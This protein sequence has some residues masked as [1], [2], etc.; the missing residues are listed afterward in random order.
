[1]QR[2]VSTLC[3]CCNPQYNLI[4]LASCPLTTILTQVSILQTR[5]V[6]CYIC[7]STIA[8]SFC[9]CLGWAEATERLNEPSL[10]VF[11]S[12][13]GEHIPTRPI[14]IPVRLGGAVADQ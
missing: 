9:C 8:L 6:L 14:V 12:A 13:M 11:L 5:S 7:L 4:H 10:C 2:W 3:S 1:M